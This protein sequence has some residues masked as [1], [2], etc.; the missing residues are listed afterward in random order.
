MQKEERAH[1]DLHT[2][3]ACSILSVLRGFDLYKVLFIDLS[4][5]SGGKGEE[6]KAT[7]WFK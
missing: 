5:P 7:S 3:L 2:K 6:R 1:L 4:I